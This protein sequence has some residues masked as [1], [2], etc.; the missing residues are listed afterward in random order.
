MGMLEDLKEY[1]ENNR[2]ECEIF[3]LSDYDKNKIRFNKFT[4]LL[5]DGYDFD[6]LIYRLVLVN[7]S[8]E[9]IEK[10][11]SDGCEPY[12]T[13]L[14]QF[15]LAYIDHFGTEVKIKELEC[16]FINSILEFNGYYF[17]EIHGQ[18]L[19]CRIYNKEDLT[20]MLQI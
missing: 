11:Y 7:G 5:N 20:M 6:K 8:D 1:V 16:D 4:N 15:V 9:W 19:I 2:E 12:P 14:L 17:Q 3:F 13:N 18:G 10:C